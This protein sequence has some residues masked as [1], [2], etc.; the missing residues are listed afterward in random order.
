[1]A[2]FNVLLLL[3]GVLKTHNAQQES[4]VSEWSCFTLQN[5]N[6]DLLL[7]LFNSNPESMLYLLILDV[8]ECNLCA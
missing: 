4:V 7:L 5:S 6:M 3:L 8:T 1:M 2:I